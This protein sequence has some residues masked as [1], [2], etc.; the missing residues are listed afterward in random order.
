METTKR[1]KRNSILASNDENGGK[2]L[3]LNDELIANHKAIEN[4]T[5]KALIVFRNNMKSEF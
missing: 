4:N 3:K 1:R 5:N 2:C